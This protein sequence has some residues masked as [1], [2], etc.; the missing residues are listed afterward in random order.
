MNKNELIVL[1]FGTTSVC[2]VDTL[3]IRE[4]WMH[5]VAIDIRELIAQGNRVV[6]F[7]SGG[8]ATGIKRGRRSLQNDLLLENKNLLG[9]LGLSELLH[10]WQKCFDKINLPTTTLTVREE[11]IETTPVCDLI[12]DMTM[13]G[14]VPI[15]NENIPLQTSFNNDELAAKICSRLHASK[16]VLFTDTDGIFT[17]NPKTN[18]NARHLKEININALSIS[19]AEEESSLGSGGMKAKL[20]SAA[21]VKRQGIETIIANGVDLHPLRNLEIAEKHT[22]LKS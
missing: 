2:N 4:D 13:H 7:S 3:E 6:I 14:I 10:T 9:A 22:I 17:D 21:K 19:V 8:L 16:F 12:S 15:I 5:S 1:K 18:P 11:D 20:K